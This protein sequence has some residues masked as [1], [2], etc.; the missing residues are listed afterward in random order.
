MTSRV[1]CGVPHRSVVGARSNENQS[2]QTTYSHPVYGSRV[3]TSTRTPSQR[4]RASLRSPQ[5]REP[6]DLGWSNRR[7]C[8]ALG[9]EA[10]AI[11]THLDS[12]PR[13]NGAGTE[14]HRAHRA[15]D[16]QNR[17]G[18]V[19]FEGSGFRRSRRGLDRP[20]G[21]W[22]IDE[23][24]TGKA[25]RS[26]PESRGV[27]DTGRRSGHRPGCRVRFLQEPCRRFWRR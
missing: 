16:P 3:G 7:E 11:S 23:N 21:G 13:S 15:D 19:V 25:C 10:T 9:R 12:S 1:A 17:R 2:E 18:P 4:R 6:S 26:E 22:R 14:D 24:H 20:A 5:H 27:D 8:S